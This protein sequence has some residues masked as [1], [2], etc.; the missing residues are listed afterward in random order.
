[1]QFINFPIAP[2]KPKN[3]EKFTRNQ[4]KQVFYSIPKHN[5]QI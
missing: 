4:P 5:V 2:Q 1:M 3:I